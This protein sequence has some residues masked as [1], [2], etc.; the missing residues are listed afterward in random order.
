MFSK[1]LYLL[2]SNCVKRNTE[3][4]LAEER[5]KAL[6]LGDCYDLP[7]CLLRHCCVTAAIL[8]LFLPCHL[9]DLSTKHKLAALEKLC[10]AVAEYFGSSLLAFIYHKGRSDLQ[11]WLKTSM[12]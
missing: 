7:L 10:N 3:L 5:K 12:Y 9:P 8:K 11:S 6:E 2:L 1:L 4:L